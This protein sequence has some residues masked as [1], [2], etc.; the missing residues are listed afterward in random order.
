[1]SNE[2]TRIVLE[3]VPK[4]GFYEGGPK[5]PEDVPFPSCLRSYL[6][7]IGDSYGCEHT[8]DQGKNSKIGCAYSYLM[9]TSGCA[10]RLSWKKG[11]HG[12]NLEIAY[13]SENP[14]EPFRR[15]F[16]SVGYDY[17]FIGKDK[18]EITFRNRIIESIKKGRPVL[19]Y[20]IIGPPESCIITGYDENGN[21]LIGWNFFQ[22]FPEFTDGLEF[23]PSGYFRKRNWYKDIHGITLIGDKK[24]K[25][26]QK[27]IYTEAL[28]WAL[29]VAK[30]PMVYSETY[31]GDEAWKDRYN[32]VSAY[33]A[34]ADQLLNDDDFPLDNI[35]LL[36]E[37]HTIHNDA[38]GTIAEGRWYGS[39]F[40]SLVARQIPQMAEALYK[41]ASCYAEEHD[42]MWKVWSIAGNFGC[43]E[44]KLKE[45]AKP[46][47][48]RE[49][50]KVILQARDKDVEASEHI[51]RALNYKSYY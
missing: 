29:K 10:F 5:C 1:M 33:N 14:A 43:D 21:V 7:F 36:R 2:F 35:P 12:D 11:W 8:T 42:L 24:E 51:E 6:E 49:A 26:P 20:G 39:L 27:E 13:M 16:E 23:E 4:V 3:G 50:V 41:T 22:N 34:W 32:G 37:R 18:D 31:N 45:F 30:T 15:A 9:G 25:A 47:V 28:K 40:I 19:T 17:E 44:E 48:R 38:V 46:E